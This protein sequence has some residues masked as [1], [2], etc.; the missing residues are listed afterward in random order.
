MPRMAAA[1]AKQRTAWSVDI[2]G[3]CFRSGSSL[4]SALSRRSAETR[5]RRTAG[6][7]TAKICPV[8]T[9]SSGW[10][11]SDQPG[12]PNWLRPLAA[13]L[14]RGEHVGGVCRQQSQR[15]DVA[16]ADRGDRRGQEDRDPSRS[17][18]GGA[19]DGIYEYRFRRGRHRS[20]SRYL[21][22]FGGRIRVRMATK[23]SKP[24]YSRGQVAYSRHP[25][26]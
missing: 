24:G 22:G 9:S 25:N 11:R 5:P 14:K 21:G 10:K 1:H 18:P 23:H 19:P 7:M 15:Q 4:G 13:R 2:F 8:S 26:G 12:A 6:T 3:S 17:G 16:R 20:C